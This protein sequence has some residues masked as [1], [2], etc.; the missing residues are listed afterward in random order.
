[1]IDMINKMEQSVI[2]SLSGMDKGYGMRKFYIQ[3]KTGI[4]IDMLTVIL[5]RLKL[6][7]KIE[8]IMIWSESNGRPNGSGYRLTDDINNI[9]YV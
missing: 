2:E 3:K 8:L 6:A 9:N 1:M 5:K 7:G 4:P